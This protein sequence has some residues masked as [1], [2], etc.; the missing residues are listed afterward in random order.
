MSTVTKNTIVP[1]YFNS[2][3]RANA[4]DSTTNYTISLRK[5]LHNISSIDVSNVT[6]PKTYTNINVNNS[7]LLITF[8]DQLSISDITVSVAAGTYTGTELATAWQDS[9]NSNSMFISL[10]VVWTF[11]Y[12]TIT[13]KFFISIVYQKGTTSTLWG[14]D[15][16]YTPVVD[17]LGIGDGVSTYSHRIQ[18]PNLSDSFSISIGR[19]ASLGGSIGIN[20]TSDILTTDTDTSYIE[21][22]G[23][24][25]DVSSSNNT[26]VLNEKRSH[27][28]Y[29]DAIPYGTGSTGFRQ[30]G[31]RI[32]SSSDGSNIIIL[33]SGN[34]N[35]PLSGFAT[36]FNR[37]SGVQWVQNGDIMAL[38]GYI[39]WSVGMSHD[40]N[41]LAVGGISSGGE[42]H[43]YEQVNNIWNFRQAITSTHADLTT[44]LG[45]MISLNSTGDILVTGS[46]SASAM[47]YKL[48]NIT[49]DWEYLQNLI[50]TGL[51]D[52]IIATFYASNCK[53]SADGSRIYVSAPG[54]NSFVGSIV[55]FWFDGGTYVQKSILTPPD[56]IGQSQMGISN[57]DHPLAI[58][59]SGAWVVS[60]SSEDDGGAGAVWVFNVLDNGG[61][62]FTVDS[63]TAIRH[64]K[65]G[66]GTSVSI[67][68]DATVLVVGTLDETTPMTGSFI[69]LTGTAPFFSDSTQ[70]VNWPTTIVTA[71]LTSFGESIVDISNDGTVISVSAQ[72]YDYND[73]GVLIYEKNGATWELSQGPIQTTGGL[74]GSNQSEVISMSG[75]GNVLISA[76]IGDSSTIGAVWVYYLDGVSW[77]Q[78]GEKISPPSSIVS[79]PSPPRFGSSLCISNDGSIFAAGAYASNTAN[80]RVVVYKWDPV[81]RATSPVEH[82]ILDPISVVGSAP[83][84]F[85]WKMAMSY[86]GSTLFICAPDHSNGTVWVYKDST[87]GSANYDMQEII[88][89]IIGPTVT[90][91]AFGCASSADGSIFVTTGQSNSI[92]AVGVWVYEE[93]ISGSYVLQQ[94]FVAGSM[95]V[96]GGIVPQVDISSDGTRMVVL[97]VDIYVYHYNGSSWEHQPT[98]MS[99]VPITSVSM[100]PSGS[101]IVT[102]I[103]ISNPTDDGLISMYTY[104]NNNVW[105]GPEIKP[106]NTSRQFTSIGKSIAISDISSG[107]WIIAAGSL[108]TGGWS[109]VSSAI[110]DR[111]TQVIIPT[112]TYT[113]SELVGALNDALTL[114]NN[115]R[116]DIVFDSATRLITIT[117]VDTTT[118]GSFNT[119]I[120]NIDPSG[121]LDITFPSNAQQSKEQ[122]SDV[123]DF[124]I[125]NNILKQVNLYASQNSSIIYDSSPSISFRKYRAGFTILN[126][127]LI[128]IQ[129]RDER[130]NIVDL[131]GADWT[132]TVFATIHG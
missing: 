39:G 88:Y 56:P 101:H 117:N 46:R 76:G 82:L 75:N 18:S 41:V 62:S 24:V 102:G 27:L 78:Y 37:T 73:G 49:G 5:T 68:G 119:S 123:I 107:E 4:T 90:R 85:G 2:K 92:D 9:L 79:S 105:T 84:S 32:S 50:P 14:I 126:T 51:S 77:V 104:S 89:P 63:N 1:L 71:Q 6:I 66:F 16:P 83:V 10:G 19:I 40:G 7:T 98:S 118:N 36:V 53:I 94:Y 99:P 45:S 38:S 69:I 59:D 127:D 23:K 29:Q 64:S 31:T 26:L 33:A 47:V 129:L 113:L 58:D 115:I 52:S 96:G 21:S 43:I 109:M 122:T 8:V 112:R 80:G 103:T 61:G 12:D 13:N 81:G 125:N 87:P 95:V 110:D 15:I 131:N 128:D 91:T 124:S 74:G 116:Y 132:M 34:Y 60:G 25:F 72:A 55:F 65:P 17:V 35:G 120:F 30:F 22:I 106:V 121:T 93:S 97:S 48:S 111:Q 67:S 114:N 108:L 42:V 54:N 86:D 100:N 3:D 28:D 70:V 11:T 57:G 20:I 130:D 44:H